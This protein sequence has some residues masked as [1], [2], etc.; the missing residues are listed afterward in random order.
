MAPSAIPASQPQGN[1]YPF[2]GIY[3]VTNPISGE[4]Y[5]GSSNDIPRR[6]SFHARALIKRK[7]PNRKLSK[8]FYEVSGNLT[9]EII[10]LCLRD[11]LLARETHWIVTERSQFNLRQVPKEQKPSRKYRI[12][13][14]NGVQ[15]TSTKA[16][17]THLNVCPTTV[18][19]W[20]KEYGDDA[21]IDRSETSK[22]YL[23]KSVNIDGIEYPSIQ[24]A[25]RET[26]FGKQIVRRKA[27][28]EPIPANTKKF[29]QPVNIDGVIYR[30]YRE[31]A[32][33][34]SRHVSTIMDWHK[35]G[36]IQSA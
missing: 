7:H 28:I 22:N 5:I 24:S 35:R 15:F 16:A 23:W 8:A 31:A 14:I 25:M 4:S 19:N 30:S 2:A 6:L 3:R 1:E 20:L 34:L 27:G 10:E 29:R 11:E 17:A 12:F 32:R 36:T 13:S 21:I 18:R 26:G 9:F 33:K